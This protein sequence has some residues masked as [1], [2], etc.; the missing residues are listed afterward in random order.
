[1][2]DIRDQVRNRLNPKTLNNAS[3]WESPTCAEVRSVISLT[4]WSGSEVARQLGLKDSR[5][6]RNWQMLKTPDAKSSIPYAAW[7]LLCFYAGLGT[8]FEKSPENEA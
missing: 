5:N 1:M 7:A 8:I 4:G 6:V 3:D 2:K